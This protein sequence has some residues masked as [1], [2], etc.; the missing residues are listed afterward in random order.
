MNIDTLR[1]IAEQANAGAVG[2]AFLAGLFFSVN[3]VAIAAIPVSLAYVTKARDKRTAFLFGLMFI[4]GLIVTHVLLGVAAG[5][6]GKWVELLLG[7]FWGL[8][9]GP[10]LIFLGLVWRGWIKIPLPAA[11]FRAKRATSIWGAFALGIPF[12][13]AICPFCTPA[14]LV[15]LGVAGGLG[16]PLF[17][18]ALLLAFGIGRAIPIAAGAMAV[19]ALE[20]FKGMA[21]FQPVFETVGALAL[22]LTGLYM[23]NAYFAVIPSLAA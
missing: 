1:Q 9:L 16:S 12:S 19:G 14:L 5:F 4:L 3:P 23:L 21:R 18:A 7:R 10:L 6:G 2:I 22:I 8:L 13:V 20:H 15:L 17:G 11:S